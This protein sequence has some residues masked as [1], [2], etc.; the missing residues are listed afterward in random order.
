MALYS[1]YLIIPNFISIIQ[2]GYTL[3][4]PIPI[5]HMHYEKKLSLLQLPLSLYGSM[6]YQRS[7]HSILLYQSKGHIDSN[8]WFISLVLERGG[9]SLALM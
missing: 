5:S 8:K 6:N 3:G 7:V 9:M 4:K 2:V 1:W